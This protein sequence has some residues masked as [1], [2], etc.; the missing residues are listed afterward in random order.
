MNEGFGE[1]GVLE[2]RGSPLHYWLAGRPE[3]PLVVLTHGV[4]MDHR[5]FEAQVPI[6]AQDFRVLCWD[7]R[8]HGRSR[9]LGEG[10]SIPWVAEDLL[11]I[12][13]RVGAGP[14]ALVGHSMGGFVD[15]ELAFRGLA[16]VVAL[17]QFGSTCSTWRQPAVVR[18]GGPLTM[19]AIRWMPDAVLRPLLGY[20]GADEPSARCYATD[21]CRQVPKRDLVTIWRGILEHF[22]HEPGYRIAQPL[23]VVHGE[24]DRIGFG[25]IPWLAP[26]WA[27]REPRGR[28]V[29]IPGA[30]HNAN[31]D[32]PELF[33]RVLLAF[34]REHL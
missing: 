34:L 7:V 10:F 12:L 25:L 15:Q 21:A 9:P 8:G 29:V 28:H 1:A 13:E 17:V 2:R 3:R 33:N 5:L 32:R 23:L 19:P 14:V 4:T 26:T 6:L 27:A 11:A 31:Q 24:H 16:R 20:L 30:G 22:H 18:W